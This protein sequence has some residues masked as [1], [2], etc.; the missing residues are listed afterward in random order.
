[1]TEAACFI[2]DVRSTP[3]SDH[4]WYD[5][6]LATSP[7]GTAGA[8]PALGALA[9]GHTLVVPWRHV[10][11]VQLLEPRERA[12]FLILLEDVVAFLER[13]VGEVTVFE[14]GACRGGTGP[15]SAC[16]D[17]AHVQVLPGRYG[18]DQLHD[19][20]MRS[21]TLKAFYEAPPPFDGYLAHR[22]AGGVVSVGPDLGV[23]QYYRRRI[24]AMRGEDDEWD[25]W[26]VP[27][28]EVVLASCQLYEARWKTDVF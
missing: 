2:C 8:V 1:M 26:V 11:S 27:R 18:L 20:V 16:I 25:Y 15:R 19:A 5:R 14:H 24:C 9:I 10:H 7:G 4:A 21:P 23:S 13:E 17:H 28:H 22:D 12:D 6:V 3:A